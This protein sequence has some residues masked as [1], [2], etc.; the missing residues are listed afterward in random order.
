VP[1]QHHPVSHHRDDPVLMAKKQ[2]ID[3]YHV[4]L[5]GYFL[6]KLQATQD[7]DGSLLDHSM[8][9][10][11]GGLG[12]GNLHKHANL[13]TLIAGKLGGQIRTG[14]HLAYADNTPMANL[15]TTLLDKIGVH[16]DKIGDSNGRLPLETL[17][18]V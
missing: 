17:S 13:P 16:V 11:G 5:L 10:Y 3:T 14:Q 9:L 12:D 18:G 7:G 4:Q 1:E 6:E 2:K 8:I 15:F